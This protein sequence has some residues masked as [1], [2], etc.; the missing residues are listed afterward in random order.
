[1]EYS[2]VPEEL[3]KR[4][5][6]DDIKLAAPD[7]RLP[8]STA[9]DRVSILTRTDLERAASYGFGKPASQTSSLK[10]KASTSSQISGSDLPE[11]KDGMPEI[12]Q[13]IPLL[14]HAGNVQAPSPAPGSAD[15]ARPRHHSRRTS[16]RSFVDLP[17]DSYG[18]RG[19]GKAPKDKLDKEYYHKHPEI[20]HR[21]KQLQRHEHDRASDFAMTSEELNKLV[22]ESATKAQDEPGKLAK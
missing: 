11:D 4:S 9:R 7:P 16:A 8:S 15:G 18:L 2:V 5:V 22:R 12:G 13:R 17:E 14:A 6:G 21:E 20:M 1:M 10:E 3:L 19:H